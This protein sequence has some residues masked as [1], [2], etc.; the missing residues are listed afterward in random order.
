MQR[1]DE[2]EAWGFGYVTQLKPLKVNMSDTDPSEGG[3]SWDEVRPLEP[4][5][6]REPEPGPQEEDAGKTT[7]GDSPPMSQPAS[8]P[9]PQ[10]EAQPEPEPEPDT[11][12]TAAP[13]QS[14]PE[15]A[16]RTETQRT[17]HK[18]GPEPAPAP[19]HDLAP[20]SEAA[21]SSSDEDPAAFLRARAMAAADSQPAPEPELQGRNISPVASSPNPLLDPT[22]KAA[23]LLE[24]DQ[25][26]SQ[27]ETVHMAHELL[28]A[29]ARSR[30]SKQCK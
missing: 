6:A 19:Q 20:H 14:A 1:R 9:E 4:E 16:T 11:C 30:V 2:N 26:Q 10:P 12:K 21:D 25:K 28:A 8:E 24:L 17:P 5:P 15:A 22:G 29:L 23:Q 18:S 3:Y 27:S 13:A 7:S